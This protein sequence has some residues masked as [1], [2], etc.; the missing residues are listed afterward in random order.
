MDMCRLLILQ[1]SR[2]KNV[3]NDKGF[4]AGFKPLPD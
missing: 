2:L 1:P 3:G 4:K